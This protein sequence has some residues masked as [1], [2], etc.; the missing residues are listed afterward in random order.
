MGNTKGSVMKFLRIT[1][2]LV[3]FVIICL[4]GCAS[5]GSARTGSGAPAGGAS[6]SVRPSSSA[7]GAPSHIA[8]GDADKGATLSV[9]VG[10]TVTVT[11]TSTYWR[12]APVAGALRQVA[13]QPH[14]AHGHRPP[15]TGAGTLVATYRAVAAGTATV[16]ASRTSCGEAM[17]CT[18]A[19]GTYRVT[20]IVR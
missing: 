15:G 9:A 16:T 8:A 11:L 18:P 5:S 6:G 4:A 10:G 3:P 2:G 12:F 13:V 1:G 20:V 7:P 19:A 17:R 14:F